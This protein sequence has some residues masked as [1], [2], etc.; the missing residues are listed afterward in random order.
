[1]ADEDGDGAGDDIARF[2]GDGLPR[3]IE[4][5]TMSGW[6][7]PLGAAVGSGAFTGSGYIR[8]ARLAMIQIVPPAI[9]T[10]ISAEK[11]I[12]WRSSLA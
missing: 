11:R 5:K 8:C 2:A 12:S 6:E 3:L 1:M 10:R 9:R 4:V 7:R